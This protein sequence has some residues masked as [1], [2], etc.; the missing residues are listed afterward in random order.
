MEDIVDRYESEAVKLERMQSLK[1]VL[2]M[3]CFSDQESNLILGQYSV[4]NDRLKKLVK[5]EGEHQNVAKRSEHILFLTHGCSKEC[6]TS[7]PKK[8]QVLEKRQPIYFKILHLILKEPSLF[9]GIE[10]FIHLLLRFITLSC[11]SNL[12]N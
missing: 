6:Q 1:S 4:F 10:E 3:A 7:C 9:K 11:R 8:G 2:K 5:T 12:H